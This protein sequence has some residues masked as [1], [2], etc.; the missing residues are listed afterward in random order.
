MESPIKWVGGKRNIRKLLVSMMPEHMQY[1]EVFGGAGWVLFEKPKSKLEI[2]NDLNGDLINFYKVVQ[3]SEKCQQMIDKF[4]ILPKSRE[5]FDSYK[6]EIDNETND[7]NKA[8]MFYY[9]LKLT[10][11]GDLINPRYTIANDGRKGINYD[12]IPD[13]FWK[14]HKRLQDVYIENKDYKYIIN[15]Y[16]R[17]DGNVVFYL[18]PPYLDTFGYKTDKF[19]YENYKEMKELLDKVNGKWILTCNDKPELRKLFSDNYIFD[20]KVHYS[21]SGSSEACKD[22]NELIITN[23]NTQY[24]ANK[25][26]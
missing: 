13:E 11:G 10:F 9:L 4:S 6:I 2:F 15:K 19:T 24:V 3:N 1:V 5:L 8:V 7:I 25:V 22:Y 12:K 16:D 23:Y 20:N 14:L 18:D 21:I 17:K 26:S